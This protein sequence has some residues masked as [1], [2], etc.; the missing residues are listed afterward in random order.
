MKARIV[1][2]AL[3]LS[4]LVMGVGPALA[5]EDNVP[6]VWY[7][8]R[9]YRMGMR[10]MAACIGYMLSYSARYKGEVVRVTYKDTERFEAHSHKLEAIDIKKISKRILH[11]SH[12][13]YGG[14]CLAT[15]IR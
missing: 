7:I 3:I 6:P 8:S 10:D 14:S 2:I 11:F 12:S 1:A 13:E 15:S 4:S 9:E 5:D